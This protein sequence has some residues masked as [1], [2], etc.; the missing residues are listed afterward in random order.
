MDQRFSA[1]SA[2]FDRV[3]KRAETHFARKCSGSAC[4]GRS[5]NAASNRHVRKAAQALD[6][7]MLAC[8]DA[9]ISALQRHIE[10]RDALDA[11]QELEQELFQE[12]NDRYIRVLER[13]VEMYEK[14][15]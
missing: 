10:W 8:K 13:T 7:A 9:Q 1:V 5:P 15:V 14:R 2:Q 11:Q 4:P 6:N 3:S 12:Q